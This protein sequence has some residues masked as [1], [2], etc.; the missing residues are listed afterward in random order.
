MITR[1]ITYRPEGHQAEPR[2]ETLLPAEAGKIVSVTASYLDKHHLL[3]I[4]AEACS[5]LHC[6]VISSS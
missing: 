6:K 1:Y 2:G 3:L 5:K 4:F